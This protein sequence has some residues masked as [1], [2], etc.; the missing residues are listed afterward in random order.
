[1]HTKNSVAA[2]IIGLWMLA[3]L[4]AVTPARFSPVVEQKPN[5]YANRSGAATVG[6]TIHTVREAKH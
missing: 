6:V 5:E 4:A 3:F 2:T 1:M